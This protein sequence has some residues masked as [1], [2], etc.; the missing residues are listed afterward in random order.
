MNDELKRTHRG[1]K[2]DPYKWHEVV[3]SCK[4]RFGDTDYLEQYHTRDWI[5]DGYTLFIR[6]DLLDNNFITYLGLVCKLEQST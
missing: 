4:G 6:N 5:T 1:F 3:A 2:I